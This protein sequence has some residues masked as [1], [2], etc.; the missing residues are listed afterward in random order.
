MSTHYDVAVIGAGPAGSATACRLARQGC[1]VALI[2]RSSI[3]APRAGESLA[4]A[5]QPLLQALGAMDVLRDCRPLPSY[6]T[7]SIWGSNRAQ[8]HSHLMT[9]FL[10]GWHVDR[11]RFDRGLAELAA[12]AGADLLLASRLLELQRRRTGRFGLVIERQG[13]LCELECDFV[14]D[15]GGRAASISRRLGAKKL[16]FDKLVGIA[17]TFADAS[18]CEHCYTLVETVPEGWWYCAPIDAG[19]SAAVLMTDGDLMCRARLRNA[20]HWQAAL[21]QT[22]WVAPRL[23]ESV[24][25]DRQQVFV[26]VSQRLLRPRADRT[27]WLAAGDAA[28]AVDPISGS[29]VVRALRTAEAGATAVLVSLAGN[30]GAILEYENARDAECT[31]YLEERAAYYALEERWTALPFWARRQRALARAS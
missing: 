31:T 2:E 16:V 15:A 6:G 23:A 25:P 5:V 10:Q 7:R 17:G 20:D 22:T 8:E 1:H 3:E 24:A 30:T 29:G 28:L 11:C 13:R 27:R 9:P 14:V 19:R 21:R 12:A 18:A 4:P 26:S